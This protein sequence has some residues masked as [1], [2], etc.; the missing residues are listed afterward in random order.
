MEQISKEEM[1]KLI[2]NN[3]VHNSKKGYVDKRGYI[4]GFYHTRNKMYIEDKY[5]E[6]ARKLL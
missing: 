3:Y 4:I 1:D 5:V 2:K 6:I